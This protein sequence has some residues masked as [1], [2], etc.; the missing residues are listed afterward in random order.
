LEGI[1]IEEVENVFWILMILAEHWR[2]V[3]GMIG[4]IG[5]WFFE[6]LPYKI[7]KC[8]IPTKERLLTK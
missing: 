2:M 8:V 6:N 7:R 5:E 4:M 1:L 3:T